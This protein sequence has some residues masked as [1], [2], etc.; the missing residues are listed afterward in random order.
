MAKRHWQQSGSFL[1]TPIILGI[2][3]ISEPEAVIYGLGK[4]AK[5]LSGTIN[6]RL[7]TISGRIGGLVTNI[8]IAVL[9]NSYLVFK[10]RIIKF[11]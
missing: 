1:T 10:T 8:K 11:N 4:H 7:N 3:S 2:K 6:K 5:L 9:I